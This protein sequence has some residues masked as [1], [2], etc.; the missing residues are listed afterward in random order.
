MKQPTR[1]VVYEY[2]AFNMY[3]SGD[4]VWQFKDERR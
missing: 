4:S 3:R 1:V 2:D